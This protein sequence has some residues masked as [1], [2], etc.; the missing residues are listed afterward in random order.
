MSLEIRGPNARHKISL[1]ARPAGQIL[2]RDRAGD[3]AETPMI[4]DLREVGGGP[5]RFVVDDR[6]VVAAG[7]QGFT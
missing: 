7:Q 6:H 5:R 4:Q 2:V 3:E 1:Q